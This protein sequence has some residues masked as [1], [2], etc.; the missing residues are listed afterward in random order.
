MIRPDDILAVG[1]YAG[2]ASIPAEYN[3]LGSACGVI[4]VWTRA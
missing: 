2:P 4:L 3:P 1:A